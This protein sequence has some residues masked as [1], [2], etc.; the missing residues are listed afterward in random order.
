M[1]NTESMGAFTRDNG[2]ACA[3]RP[4]SVSD[5]ARIQTVEGAA[6]DVSPRPVALTIEA[7][8]TQ[9]GQFFASGGF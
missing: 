2:A 4:T 8:E 7:V 5:R 6:S 1:S 3:G 9:I